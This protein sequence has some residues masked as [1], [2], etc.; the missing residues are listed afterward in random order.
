MERQFSMKQFFGRFGGDPESAI[1]FRRE[2]IEPLLIETEPI[3]LDFAGMAGINS[4]FA[5]ALIANLVQQ[6]SESILQKLRYENCSASMLALLH[7]AAQIGSDR[8]S[9]RKLEVAS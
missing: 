9:V 4:S 5:N 2:F 8:H 6:H 1:R 3:V 7:L